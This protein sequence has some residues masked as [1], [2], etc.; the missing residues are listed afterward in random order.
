MSTAFQAAAD[1]AEIG[2]AD[3][4]S[5]RLRNNLRGILTP[6]VLVGIILLGI[7]VIVAIIGPLVA[8]YDPSATTG[9]VLQGPS[10]TYLLG[11][12]QT[13][14][15]VLS[16]L[17]AGTRSSLVIAFS[18]GAFATAISVL[19][20]TASG[21]IGGLVD[22]VLSLVT[23][24]YLVIPALPLAIVLSA[25]LPNGGELA[26]V[27]VISITG[28]SWGARVI[29]VQALSLRNRD[30]ILTARA[31][32]EST[33]RLILVDMLPDMLP[34]IA[35]QFLSLVIFAILTEAGLAFLG[36]GGTGG[37][38]W[39]NMLFW[40]TEDTAWSQGAW[41]WFLPPG[42]CIALVGTSLALIN[43][44]IDEVLNPR[45]RSARQARQARGRLTPAVT[46]AEVGA[47]P[48]AGA[49]DR[50][51]LLEVR[52]LT[53]RYETGEDPVRAVNHVSLDLR[54]GE[55]LGIAGESGCG[56]TTLAYAICQILRPP[57]AIAGGQM[58]YHQAEVPPVDLLAM[59]AEQRRSFRWQ[60]LSVVFQS[61][62]NSLNPVIDIASQ[63][64]DSLK[65]HRPDWSKSQRTARAEELL[66]MVGIRPDRLRSFPHEL[67]GGMRQRVA[68]AMA[69][70]LEPAIVVMDE[71]TTA[72]DV[73]VQREILEQLRDMRARFEFAMIFITHDLSLLI[74]F[75]DRIAVMYAGS[76]AEI[77]KAEDIYKRPGHPYTAGLAA[78]FP[79]LHGPL[80]EVQGIP[81]SPPDLRLE[82]S[83][84]PFEPRC[85]YSFK[86]CHDARPALRPGLPP[87]H[88]RSL[89]ACYLHDPS[90][91]RP[92]PAATPVETTDA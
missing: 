6:S 59:S 30:Y 26:L 35:A 55:V 69:L 54:R 5:I 50:P 52:D 15:D 89:V 75:A 53:V 24:V 27:L 13:G 42:L 28:W 33:L 51:V 73:V 4:V 9:P 25:Y 57:A 32:G 79:N 39:G 23:N 49:D 11:T 83:G 43:F 67:S 91:G 61:A 88:D 17:L 34:V 70:V 64:T 72:L 44:G 46:S 16:Q 65:V 62:M 21:L 38:S 37:W 47:P 40:A 45:L 80:R 48:A 22:E 1:A 92:L 78:C 74:E 19:V 76:I 10:L 58:I 63:M 60:E 68:I 85:P 8:P 20:G 14:Q 18:A 66:S 29:R 90:A 41:W 3:S 36:L 87:D 81:G 31:S 84:C 77:G 56:K 7:F 71:P 2:A 82:I 86:P 12:T